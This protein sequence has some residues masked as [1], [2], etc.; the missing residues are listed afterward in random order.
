MLTLRQIVKG[1]ALDKFFEF[2]D[3][4]EMLSGRSLGLL[5]LGEVLN[6]ALHVFDRVELSLAL[7]GLK[8]FV[9][10]SLDFS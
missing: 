5:E 7:L 3:H 1:A 6:H 2:L 9:Y 10:Q 4:V 8:E